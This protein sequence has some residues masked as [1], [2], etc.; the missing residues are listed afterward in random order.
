M[1]NNF[2]LKHLKQVAS[3][4]L[5]NA[6]QSCTLL[7]C[8]SHSYTALVTLHMWIITYFTETTPPWYLHCH[9][10]S[11][12]IRCL[13]LCKCLSESR[14]ATLSGST[15]ML[16]LCKLLNLKGE[17]TGQSCQ[18]YMMLHMNRKTMLPIWQE[19]SYVLC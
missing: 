19:V 1:S 7:Y 18:C 3:S 13:S 6:F 9:G 10:G 4:I 5:S 2:L 15:Q 8:L 11:M 17:A 14:E 16:S 12:S